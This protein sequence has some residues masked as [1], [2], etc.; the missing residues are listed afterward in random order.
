M[1]KSIITK[2]GIVA[3]AVAFLSLSSCEKYLDEVRPNPNSP[4][5]VT[6]DNLLANVEVATFSN[7]EGNNARRAGIFT[8]QFAG[9]DGQMAIIEGYTVTEGDVT[10]EWKTI[11]TSALINAQILINKAG[12]ANPYYRGIA[13][14]LKAMNLGLATDQWGDVPSSEAL[15]GDSTGDFT[16]AYAAQA[17]VLNDLQTLLSAAIVDLGAAQS[18]NLSFPTTSDFIFSGDNLKWTKIAW[19]LKA[20]YANRLS[21]RSPSQSATDVLTYLGNANMVDNSDDANCIFGSNGNENNQWFAFNSTR[22]GYIRMGKFFMDMMNTQND[23]RVPF[24]ATLDDTGAYTG[25][26]V[27]SGDI[28]T[29][30]LGT[31]YGGPTSIAPLCT[32]V[33]AKFMEAE[34]NFRLGN[35]AAAASAQ[36]EAVAASILAVTG[37]TNPVYE[38]AH[39]NETG[40]TITLD[41]IMTEKYVAMFTQVEVWTDWRR[42]GI[43]NL[44]PNPAGAVNGIPRSLPTS[45]DERVNNPNAPIQSNILNHVW[46]D[47]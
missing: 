14:V 11:Y 24:Y 38:A 5:D 27:G 19:V 9:T 7:F 25:S 16:P 23:P 34:A 35:T 10:N 30:Q 15:L 6:M 26:P 28:T 37:T 2:S 17:T 31:Y 18:A 21:L 33:E 8:Q 40:G 47:L 41:K 39:A 42:T 32:F 4:E 46:W 20:R 22:A 36:N 3:V 43:P 44:T 1:K 13:E 45:Q 12:T 29:S